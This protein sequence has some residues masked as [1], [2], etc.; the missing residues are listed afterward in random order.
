MVFV[1]LR[2]LTDPGCYIRLHFQEIKNI[3]YAFL[4]RV[5]VS[6]W[7]QL[8]TTPRQVTITASSSGSAVVQ[9]EADYNIKDPDDTEDLNIVVD[10]EVDTIGKVNVKTCVK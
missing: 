3:L 1:H 2:N 6:Y 8:S 7:F 10:T 4:L 9:L 5:S